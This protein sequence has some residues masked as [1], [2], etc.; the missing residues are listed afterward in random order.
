MQIV[1]THDY[2]SE[3]LI[4]QPQQK[5]GNRVVKASLAV[6]AL[7][8]TAWAGERFGEFNARS[9]DA[10][11][12]EGVE[13]FT[14]IIAKPKRGSCSKY[15]E[16]CF[17]TGCCSVVGYSCYTTQ[18]G[19]AKCLKNCT[20]SATQSCTQPQGMMDPILQDAVHVESSV[21][22]FAVY[23]KDTGS[24]KTSHELEILQYA[25][26][27]GTHIFAC[28]QWDVF[29]D[30]EV[31]IGGVMTTKV[32]DVEGDFHFAKRKVSGTWVNTGLF[33][34]VWRSIQNGGKY[35]QANWVA[36]V[37]GDAV[38]IP[39]R[40]RSWLSKQMVPAPG[41]YLENCKFVDYGYFGN[42][43]V[44]STA[45]FR[46]LLQNINTCKSS[47]N[48]KVGV[49]D[50]KYGPMGEDLFAQSCLDSAGIRRKEAFDIT[51]GGACPAHRPKGEKKT[52]KWKPN[53]AYAAT[54][55]MHPFKKTQ[56]WIQCY[57]A[58]T[59]AFGAQVTQALSRSFARN[60]SHSWKLES[61]M[62][63]I[64]FEHASIALA[65]SLFSGAASQTSGRCRRVNE[66]EKKK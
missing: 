60:F 26:S 23:T 31:D 38:F 14:Q 21:Y 15:T 16:D 11:D 47:L 27:K 54:P 45:A 43:E 46:T 7:C 50:G 18:P 32:T 49:K 56:E 4:S 20:P 61:C 36:K 42:L 5:S 39:T 19:K 34:Q 33:T 3:G 52:K 57:E 24:T 22:C 25:K 63:E 37:D 6:A 55:A 48:W 28:D 2:D 9:A 58:T 10:A 35:E 40:L 44:F 13:Q 8:A 1:D 59:A 29:S 41:I 17:A 66:K 62:R 53:C 30:V 64:S 65:G 51:T 12:V